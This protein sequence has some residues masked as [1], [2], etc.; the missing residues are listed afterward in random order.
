[1]G[2]NSTFMLTAGEQRGEAVT[3]RLRLQLPTAPLCHRQLRPRFVE[4]NATPPT[5]G[6]AHG[7]RSR[8]RAQPQ[9][10]GTRRRP[11]QRCPP[12]AVRH[13]FYSRSSE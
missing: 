13:S 4:Q 10:A 12:K 9:Q 1:M 8:V 5:A 2:A 11:P 3:G 7:R 6:A